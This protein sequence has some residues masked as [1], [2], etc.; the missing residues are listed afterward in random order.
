MTNEHT[1][2]VF[3]DN[4]CSYL[5]YARIIGPIVI[6]LVIYLFTIIIPSLVTLL[7]LLTA[8]VIF[9][10]IAILVFFL[11]FVYY[12]QIGNH[13]VNSL[14][15]QQF[16][17]DLNPCQQD[18]D[19]FVII[20]SMGVYFLGYAGFDILIN[21]FTSERYA[22]KIYH[23]YNPEDFKKVLK[24]ERAKYIWIFG[25][26]WRGGVTFKWTRSISHLLTPNKSQLSYKKIQD[27]LEKYP[28]KLFIGQFHCNHIAK[29]IPD[30]V[31]L[32]EILLET[33]NDSNYY[34]S[35]WKMNTISIWFAIRKLVK[36]VKRTEVPITVNENE[37]NAGGCTII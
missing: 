30:N 19:A 1:T 7:H 2:I 5:P 25:H 29:T 34:V 24:N 11:D 23:C 12:P 8:A 3:S 9:L 27:E 20:H 35:N 17:E 31:S 36:E 22:F 4:W 16:P 26:G 18:H 21:Y 37:P 13:S 6:I 10:I 28:K 14:K 33:S 32:P 15:N